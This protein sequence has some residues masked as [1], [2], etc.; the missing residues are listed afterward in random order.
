M[1]LEP[2]VNNGL[3]CDELDHNLTVIELSRPDASKL[4]DERSRWIR[5]RISFGMG[6]L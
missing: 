2:E 5:D 6:N 3:G 1:R 4:K